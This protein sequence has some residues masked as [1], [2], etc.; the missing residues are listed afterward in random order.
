MISDHRHIRGRLALP[1]AELTKS[2][3]V[4]SIKHRPAYIVDTQHM[5]RYLKHSFAFR[6]VLWD[7]GNPL[8]PSGYFKYHQI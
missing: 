1:T 6:P 5:L 3:T 4:R 2:L 8:K 7:I